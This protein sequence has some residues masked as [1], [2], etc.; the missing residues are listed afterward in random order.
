MFKEG[1]HIS[2][3]TVHN[4]LQSKSRVIPINQ[5]AMP[6]CVIWLRLAMIV[7]VI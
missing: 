4:T 2:F 6:E 5:S 3:I 7:A 1:A